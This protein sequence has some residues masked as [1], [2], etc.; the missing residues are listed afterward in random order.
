M[1]AAFALTLSLALVACDDARTVRQYDVI[2]GAVAGVHVDTGEISVEF[3]PPG[4]G[5][6]S[7]VLSCVVTRDTEL[8]LND[9]ITSLDRIA[10]GDLIQIVGTRDPDPRLDRLAI[11]TAYVARDEPAAPNPPLALTT[12]R[13]TE[14]AEGAK[15]NDNS[16]GD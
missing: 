1:Q 2:Q 3:M 6:K 14:R 5:A 10:T 11:N 15:S 8:Y 16:S 12:T 9:R 7:R 4:P 13:N